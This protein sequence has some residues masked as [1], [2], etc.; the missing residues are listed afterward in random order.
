MKFTL[1]TFLSSLIL[2][3]SC[4]IPEHYFTA[5]P[6]CNSEIPNS[7]NEENQRKLIEQLK[8]KKPTDYRYFFKTFQEDESD[9]YMVTNFR[10]KESCFDL[11]IVVDDWGKLAGMRRKNGVSYPEE[12]YDLKWVIES[13]N[14]RDVMKYID[15]HEIID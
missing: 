8:N 12:L 4:N 15:M 3:S 11:R 5:K 2:L 14:G 6:E 7:L 10:N 9:T 1:Y 13:I